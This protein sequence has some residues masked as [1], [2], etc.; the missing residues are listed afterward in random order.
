MAE[1][2]PARASAWKEWLP[3]ISTIFALAG[4]LLYGGQLIGKLVELERRVAQLE[5]KSDAAADLDR[6]LSRIEGK[7]D[8]LATSNEGKK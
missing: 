7:L 6:R 2:A 8:V 4:I 5:T 1:P 3:A